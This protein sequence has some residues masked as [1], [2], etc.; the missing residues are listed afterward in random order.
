MSL[1]PTVAHL[2]DTAAADPDSDEDALIA[3]LEADEAVDAFRERRL[4]QLHEE[5]NRAKQLRSSE[6]GTYTEIKDEKTLMDITT[7]TKYCVVHFFKPDFGRCAV[8]DGHLE[9]LAPTHYETRI[10]RIN[11][12]NAPFLI[13]K[14]KIQVLPCVIAFVDGV[15]VDR[16]I[17]FEGLGRT[18]DTFT[19]R[20]LE[21]RLI[22]AGVLVREKVQGV[23]KGTA[24]RRGKV[25]EED[26]GDD[27]D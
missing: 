16:V 12:D 21:A 18:P 25:A 15:G 23:K 4:Q 22:R 3:S 27:W 6:H 7:S 5:F 1:D 17:G 19:T 26:S 14:L 13:T 9:S 10:V 24:V 11:V 2:V 8:M 20:D